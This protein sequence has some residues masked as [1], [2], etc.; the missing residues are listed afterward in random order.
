MKLL[1]L[2]KRADGKTKKWKNWTNIERYPGGFVEEFYNIQRCESF[3]LVPGTSLKHNILMG[4]TYLVMLVWCFLGIAIIS[5]IFME[6]IEMITAQTFNMELW[7][8][9]K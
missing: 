4:V 5:D 7:D 6:A 2:A 3:V 8:K 9:E 1:Y